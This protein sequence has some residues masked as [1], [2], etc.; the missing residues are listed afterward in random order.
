MKTRSSTTYSQV[1]NELQ[2]VIRQ[3]Q[4]YRLKIT[5]LMTCQQIK[6]H[7]CDVKEQK[8]AGPHQKIPRKHLCCVIIIKYNE[9][10]CKNN[11]IIETTIM[12]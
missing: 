11:I 7:F 6:P 5:V 1:K 4:K 12:I 2:F 10:P 3:G 8:R 9:E